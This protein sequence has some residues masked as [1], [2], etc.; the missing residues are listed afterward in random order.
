MHNRDH[1][2][3]QSQANHILR[4]SFSQ[5]IS[6]GTEINQMN[7]HIYL[8]ICRSSTTLTADVCRNISN[9]E[10]LL[11]MITSK[12]KICVVCK[13]NTFHLIRHF[14]SLIHIDYK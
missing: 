6:H 14:I 3:V 12:Q 4:A 13:S 11:K 8:F 9:I 2:A 10:Q 1:V 7:P 5:N